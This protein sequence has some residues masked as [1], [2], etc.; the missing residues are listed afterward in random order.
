MKSSESDL[1][2]L[3]DL[4]SVNLKTSEL[5][6]VIEVTVKS[7]KGGRRGHIMGTIATIR[8]LS[9][10]SKATA[11]IARLQALA[12]MAEKGE[13][14]YWILA[15]ETDFSPTIAHRALISAA[16][17]HPLSLRNGEFVFERESFLSKVLELA[18]PEGNLQ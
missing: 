13:L 11:I 9:Y 2:Q 6:R 5:L 10:S 7:R 17:R 1:N 18:E 16:A 3:S 4:N 15:E 12:R 8:N 14:K